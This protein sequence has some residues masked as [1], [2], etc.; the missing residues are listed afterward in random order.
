MNFKILYT[1]KF[2][3]NL[4]KQGGFYINHL[5]ILSKFTSFLKTIMFNC[6]NLSLFYFY[7]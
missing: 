6:F 7:S 3:K 5:K 2:I 1:Q 4:K